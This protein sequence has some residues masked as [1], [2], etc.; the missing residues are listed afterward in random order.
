MLYG[1][2]S[3]AVISKLALGESYDVVPPYSPMNK[4]M[5]ILRKYYFSIMF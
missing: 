1:M 5:L 2:P 4:H 3:I